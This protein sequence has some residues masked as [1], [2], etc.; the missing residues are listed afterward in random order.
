MM[1]IRKKFVSEFLAAAAVVIAGV[2][3]S[4]ALADGLYDNYRIVVIDVKSQKDFFMASQ[5][6]RPLACWPGPG[7]NEFL[8]APDA[9]D[10]LNESG[11]PHVV[12][13]ENVQRL[14]DEES[15]ANTRARAERGADFFAAYRTITEIND[16]LLELDALPDLP[17]DTVT[18]FPI[19]Q[20]IQGRSVYAIRVSTPPLPGQPPKP[21]FLITA[22]QHAREWIG[23]SSGMFIVDKLV[24]GYATNP[25]IASLVDNIEFVF[26]PV[27]NPDGYNYTFPT[28][29]G[30][31]GDRY[32]RKNL[33]NNGGSTGVDTNRNWGY[34]WGGAGASTLPSSDTYRGAG[35]FSEPETQNV[36]NLVEGLAGLPGLPNLKAMIDLHTYSELVLS[37][38]GWSSATPPRFD[39]ISPLTNAQITAMNFV[40]NQSFT[41]G[42]ASTTLYFASGTAPDWGFGARNALSWTYELRPLGPGGLSGFNLPVSQIVVAGEEAWAG[43]TS[44]TDH[45]QQRLQIQTTSVTSPLPLIGGGFI[46]AQ[47]N[48]LNAYTLDTASPRLFWRIGNSGPFTETVMTPIAPAGRYTASLV[49]PPCGESLQYYLQAE[50]TDGGV[51]VHPTDAPVAALTIPGAACPDCVG[52]ADGNRSLDFVDITAIITNWGAIGTAGPPGNIG[53]ANYDGVV[54]FGDIN[55]VIAHWGQTCP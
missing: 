33:R 35:P 51:A 38:W 55:A 25:A 39:E 5:L 34:Q 2:A 13:V 32:W 26:V 6:G 1:R 16:Y 45:I 53:D 54:N 19:G 18:R 8:V 41:G 27:V 7:P 10:A 29:Q 17:A 4:P 22:G 52:D 3:A 46:T 11:I 36:R 47:F 23:V 21:T 48:A 42:P 43:I 20:S 15:E 28:N 9:M 49:S 14:I 12:T 50:T 30:G 40:D 44:I 31:G 37:P 24:R